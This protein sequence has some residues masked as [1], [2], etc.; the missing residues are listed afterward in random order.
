ML[1][2]RHCIP[3]PDSVSYIDGAFIA[4][5]GSTAFAALRRLGVE[6]HRTLAVYG[7]GPVGL[8]TVILAKAMGM[9]VIGVDVIA[10]RVALA[11]E[12]GADDVLDATETDVVERVRAFGATGGAGYIDGVDYV[13]EASGSAPARRNV[14]PSLGFRTGGKAAL[15]GVGNDEEVIKASDLITNGVTLIG[16]VVFPQA[17]AWDLSRFLSVSGVSF[18]PS[19]THRFALEDAGEALHIADEGSCGKVVLL[20]HG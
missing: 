3:L 11:L 1:P 5:I 17:W 18:E 4:C 15:L 14:V 12:C 2:E 13:I 16:S 10:E 6:A 7:L 20:P 19:V 8:S 9:K